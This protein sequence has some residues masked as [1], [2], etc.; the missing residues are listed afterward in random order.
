MSSFSY[1]QSTYYLNSTDG[2]DSYTGANPTNAVFG[3]G[4]KRTLEGAFAA[5]PDGATVYMAAGNYNYDQSGI[6]GGNDANGYT[7]PSVAANKSMTF[8]VQTYNSNNVAS[9]NGGPLTIQNGTGTITF[10]AETAGTQSISFDGNTIT[11]TSGKLDVTG[12]TFAA[13]ATLGAINRVDGALVGAPT[14]AN[15]S[16]VLTYTNTGDISAGGEVPGTLG[17]LNLNGTAGKKVTFSNP[18]VFN[19]N[20]GGIFN[21]TGEDAVFN[22]LVTLKANATN[23]T[24][25]IFNNVNAADW[26]FAGGVLVQMTQNDAGANTGTIT[27]NGTGSVVVTGALT[28]EQRDVAGVTNAS[29]TAIVENLAAGKVNLTGGVIENT[30]TVP[31]SGTNYTSAAGT[32]YTPVV[33]YNNAAAGQVEIGGG[34]STTFTGTFTTGAAAGKVTLKGPVT[35]VGALT[36][37][38]GHTIALGSS[39]LTLKAGLTNGGTF[40]SAGVGSGWLV[41]TVATTDAT[42]GTFSNIKS[43]ATGAVSLTTSATIAGS[44]ENAGTSTITIAG[45]TTV[46]GNVT[47]NSGA[48]LITLSAGNVNGNITSAAGGVTLGGAGTVGG[49]ITINGGT[50]TTNVTTVNGAVTMN[51]GGFTLGGNTTLMAAYTQNAGTLTFGVNTLACKSNF[52]RISGTVNPNTG[53]LEFSAGGTQ[54]FT[55]GTNFRVYNFQVNG[56]GTGVTFL[57]GS[58]EVMNDA[59]IVSNTNVKLGSYNIRMLGL[60]G[61]GSTYSN[62]GQVLVDPVDGGGGIIFEAPDA[63]G[64]STVGLISGNGIN[65]NIEIRLADETDHIDIAGGQIV[66]WS[67]ILTLTRGTISVP[68]GT[69]FNP[70][71]SLTTPTI[72]RNLGD[73]NT[74]GGADGKALSVAGTFNATNVSYNLEYVGTGM[75]AVENVGPEFVT[76]ATPRVINLKVTA[77]GNIVNLPATVGLDYGF[78]GN[79]TVAN[80][81]VLQLAGTAT[82]GDLVS[83]GAAASHVINGK[84]TA[85]GTA[86]FILAGGGTVTG[87]TKSTA[88]ADDAQIDA[89]TVNTTGS[90]DV[91]DLKLLGALTNVAGTTN[92]GMQLFGSPADEGNVNALTIT[93][94]AVNLKK[95]AD[96]AGAFAISDGSF[97]TDNNNLYVIAG[98]SVTATGGTI[99]A[100]NASDKGYVVFEANGNLNSGTVAVPRVQILNGI[101]A[102]LTGSSVISDIFTDYDKNG[103]G[104]L[105]MGA[106][107]LTLTAGTWNAKGTYTGTG[108]VIVKGATKVNLAASI[109]IPNLTVDNGTNT[110]E[111]VDNDGATATVPAL[112]VGT[113]YNQKAGKLSLGVVD[114]ILTNAGNAFTYDAGSIDATTSNT[115]TATN[116]A[117]GELV[118]NNAGNGTFTVNADG[119]VI[120]NVRVANTGNFSLA[121]AAN[122]AFT[123]SKR[124]V[125]ENTGDFNFLA[126]EKLMLGD[127]AWVKRMNNGGV[128]DKAP[129]FNGVVSLHYEATAAI[130]P[131]K[132][133]PASLSVK[134]L[135]VKNTGAD[136]DAAKSITVTDML[137]LYS[138][139]YD[140][141]QTAGTI[142]TITMGAN[143]T[144]NVRE[145]KVYNSGSTTKTGLAGGPVTLI[146]SNVTTTPY[147]TTVQEFPTTAGFVSKLQVNSN[148]AATSVGLKLDAN[149]SVGDFVLESGE[150][151]TPKNDVRFDLNGKTLTVTNT[152]SAVLTRGI[153]SSEATS[154]GNM[155][156]GT[157]AAAGSLTS[158]ANTEIHNVNITAA[159][160]T[161]AGPFTQVSYGG[162]A[163][164]TTGST[165]TGLATIVAYKGN[166]TANDNLTVNGAYTGGTITASK[167]VTI[168]TNGSLN[169]ATNLS[170]VGS[171]SAIITVPS[172]GATV[173]ALTIKKDAATNTVTLSGGDIT[174]TAVT[175]FVNGLFV[176]GSNTF[177]MF[178]PLWGGGQG[179]DRTQV[180]G[181]KVS[182]IVG[183]VA[184]TTTNNGGPGLGGSS[185]SRIEFP[186]GT[187][188]LYRPAVLNF[189]PAFGGIP[190]VPN[191]T[192][193]VSHVSMS[194][195]GAVGLPIANGVAEGISVARYPNFY[196]NIQSEPSINNKQFDLELTATGFTDYDDL[197]NVRI[198]RRH[199]TITDE[200][201]QWLLQGTNDSYNNEL[202]AG[203][204]TAIQL[205]AQDGLRAGGAIFTLG[206]KSNMSVANPIAKQW[207]VVKDGVKSLD[208]SKVFTGNSGSLSFAAQS[209]NVTVATV[210]VSGSTLKITPVAIGQAVVT[211]VANDAANNDFFAY[212]FDVDVNTVGVETEELPTEFALYQNYPNP[213][214]PTTN[215]K[216]DLPKES[217]VSVKIYNILG[218]EVVTLVNKVMP[219][220]RH[221]V[222]FNASKLTSGMYI[223]R[224]EADNFVQVKK[225]LLMK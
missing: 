181:N 89:L 123:V 148:T 222:E 14:Y 4:P 183:K 97:D 113:L 175:T 147:T 125:L 52:T 7:L 217:N 20:S 17:T 74:A 180:T 208:I 19:T 62:A 24:P 194:P 140:F 121:A 163:V 139:G 46:T 5:F 223:Y 210:T 157:L 10:K 190:T 35:V 152:A 72:R 151:T 2:D 213:F 167:N 119:L 98:G 160:M 101:T 68:G 3:T 164:V 94:G 114:V 87:G 200:E 1:G 166:L 206:I 126:D 134:G 205:G 207:L 187:T 159:T 34:V 83:S 75:T 155:V 120:P 80:S 149:R 178:H 102:T 51:G 118:F 130:T 122:K 106:N 39:D 40:S 58:L 169:A 93:G 77:Q 144:V 221:A 36:N 22:G 116:D 184:K 203:V 109:T 85:T 204:L 209:S 142:Y 54:T 103:A 44:I 71:A 172:A 105:A 66:T 195:S 197:N 124:L 171:S 158:T 154:G 214:N 132:E 43:T 30:F 156:P 212:S 41:F 16:I 23:A 176:T 32:K 168:G 161:L 63:P 193:T 179:F 18:I 31:S 81:S 186:V 143:S 185:E 70:S 88:P 133:L 108:T 78:S 69:I 11:L 141:E 84:V 220:G 67:G 59:T 27:N 49:T 115:I 91:T 129:K 192:F 53:T 92:L 6:G 45:A 174:T 182:H 12:I 42:G 13:T 112:T 25:R 189:N 56:V 198:I 150:G 136:V 211:I 79:L 9:L 15:N 50:V 29:Y 219:A 104:T 202:S 162:G 131:G 33:S 64:A 216:F 177:N 145:G 96:L 111:L 201:N 28:F 135:Y 165:V 76:G 55:G 137:Y 61:V 21:T 173:G 90:Y 99:A 47:T 65:S 188:T 224:I 218:E 196:W 110:A 107:N 37:G 48:G 215:I 225:M 82:N 117:N 8:I 73:A 138:G 86:S 26:T 191:G 128:F 127:D 146:Y 57:N 100:T 170:F 95:S 153:L 38:A 60:G 199:G